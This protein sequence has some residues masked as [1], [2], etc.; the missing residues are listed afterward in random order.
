[1]TLNLGHSAA[2]LKRSAL[3]LCYFEMADRAFLVACGGE[4]GQF[5]GYDQGFHLSHGLHVTKCGLRQGIFHF[6]K[7]S[8]H[9]LPI[10]SKRILVVRWSQPVL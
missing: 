4:F 1:M 2:V 10:I 8:Q 6:L 5:P 3:G 9:W 7:C